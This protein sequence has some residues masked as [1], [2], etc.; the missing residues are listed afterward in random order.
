MTFKP[1]ATFEYP[2]LANGEPGQHRVYDVDIA[3]EIAEKFSGKSGDQLTNEM[4]QEWADVNW[5]VFRPIADAKIEAGKKAKN[6]K[7]WVRIDLADLKGRK[8]SEFV[9]PSKWRSR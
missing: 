6:R 3:P 1:Y 8:P 7:S 9:T 5:G 4:I 2:Y